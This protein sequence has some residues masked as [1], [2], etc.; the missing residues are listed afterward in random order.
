[1]AKQM[2]HKTNIEKS[3]PDIVQ[4]QQLFTNIAQAEKVHIMQLAGLNFQGLAERF[5]QLREIFQHYGMYKMIY[6]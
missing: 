5:P 2:T 1:M 3:K 4:M 6:C